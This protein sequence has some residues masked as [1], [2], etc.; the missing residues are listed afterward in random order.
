[1]QIKTL[2][3]LVQMLSTSISTN[4]Q[5]QFVAIVGAPASGKSTLAEQLQNAINQSLDKPVATVL[6]QDGFH[7]DNAL[8]IKLGRMEK[9]GSPDTFDV[10][11]L[12]A[13]IDRLKTESEVIAPAF[14]RSIEISRNCVHEIH[15]EHR[16]ILV[17]GNYL[18]LE[19]D[20]HWRKLQP[21]FDT[22]IFIDVPLHTLQKRLESRWIHYGLSQNEMADK[23]RNNDLP[24][25]MTVIHHS[26]QADVIF[27]SDLRDQ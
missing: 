26:A 27:R 16:L 10:S 4:S 2:N 18:L 19:N 9:K 3:Q 15:A 21:L 6:A 23:I 5:R 11:G 12:H 24:N 8:L 22:S 20:E 25:A 7:F 14:D 1:M 17:E 13:M